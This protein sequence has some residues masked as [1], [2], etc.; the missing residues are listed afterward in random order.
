MTKFQNVYII[1]MYIN[2][3]IEILILFREKLQTVDAEVQYMDPGMSKNSI[4]VWLAIIRILIIAMTT[5][6]K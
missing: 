4:L 1:Y 6:Y 3:L 5:I 2:V